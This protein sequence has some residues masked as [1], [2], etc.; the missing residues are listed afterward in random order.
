M[1]PEGDAGEVSLDVVVL[2]GLL[3]LAHPLGELALADVETD[4]TVG[5][6]A[7]AGEVGVVSVAHN[8]E[9]KMDKMLKMSNVLSKATISVALLKGT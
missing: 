1:L 9:V 2:T 8:V 3:A 7:G 6:I 4:G 5:G